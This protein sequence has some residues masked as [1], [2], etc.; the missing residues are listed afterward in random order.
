MASFSCCHW[1]FSA[2]ARSEMSASSRSRAS[3][4]AREASSFSLRRASRS[5]SSCDA[6]ALQLVE[7]DGHGV[8]LHAQ[9]AGGLV[10]EVDGLVGQEAVAD[11][12][13]REDGR[14]DEGGVGDAHTVVELVAL[15]QAAQDGDRLLDAGLVDVDGLEAPL[16]G[17]V[18][19]DVLAVLVERR[20]ADGVQLAARQHRLQQVGGVHGALGRAGA[21]DGV[22]LVDEE[23]DL[24][25]GVLDLL[26]HGLEALLELAA[27]LGAGDEGAQVE[28]HD[29]PVAQALGHVAADDAL[30][31]A[32]DDGRLADAGLADEHGVV[33]GA[34][35]EH[36]DDAAD[37]LV[38]TDDRVELAAHGPP[39]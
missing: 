12:A 30:G 2:A 14:G 5:I 17:G 21:H 31:E 36:L 11:V 34:P 27:E 7:L 15:A 24:A 18:L 23:H 35:A 28:R 9:P 16:Q 25:V 10:D 1:L 38:A 39:R 20:G 6:A 8:H 3:R 22:E 33:L 4:R 32:L 29:A 37:L 13:V 26:E 19:L